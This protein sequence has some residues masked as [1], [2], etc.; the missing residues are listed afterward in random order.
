MPRIRLRVVWGLGETMEIFWPSRLLSRVDLPTLG[1][2]M[3]ATMPDFTCSGELF[4]GAVALVSILR[5]K[6]SLLHT[7]IPDFPHP[8]SFLQPRKK[9][10][11]PGI[12]GT[13]WPVSL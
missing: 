1:G 6:A 13:Q 8:L 5:E 7:S 2:P 3:R 10:T 4:M 12:A 11:T 9:M